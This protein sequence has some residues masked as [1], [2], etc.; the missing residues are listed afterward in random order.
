MAVYVIFT[1]IAFGSLAHHQ[2]ELD[3]LAYMHDLNQIHQDLSAIFTQDRKLPGRP[4]TDLV[5][6]LVYN[7]FGPNPAAFHITIVICHL[8]ATILLTFTF[9]KAG[10]NTELSVLSGFFFLINLAHF[11][12]VQWISCLAYP[13]SLGFGCLGILMYITYQKNKQTQWYAISLLCFLLGLLSHPAAITFPLFMAYLAYQQKQP[14]RPIGILN[15][16][17]ITCL[18]LLLKLF[19]NVPQAEHATAAL[20]WHITDF[21]QHGFWYLGRLWTTT[22]IIFPQMSEIYTPDLIMGVLALVGVMLLLY[23][24]VVSVAQWGIWMLLGLAAFITNPNQTHFESGPSRHLY[25]ASAGSAAILAWIS[26]QISIKIFPQKITASKICLA[27]LITII[28]AFSIIG[29]KKSETFA[30]IISARTF[31]VTNQKE[32]ATH[33]FEKAVDIAPELVSSSM[34]ENFLITNLAKGQFLNQ[35]LHQAIALYPHNTVIVAIR[36][37]YGFQSNT[38]DHQHLTERIVEFAKKETPDTQNMIAIACLNL[39]YYYTSQEKT[40]AAETLFQGALKIQTGYPEAAI[41]LSRIY[42]SQNKISEARHVLQS[43]V[44]HNP[45]HG[46]VLKSLADIYALENNWPQAISAYEKVL[47]QKPK[48]TDVRFKL[49]YLYLVQKQYQKA[50][51]HFETLTQLSPESWQ[52]FAYLGQCLHA[53]GNFDAAKRA[54]Q[55]ALQINPDQPELQ[56]LLR[57]ITQNN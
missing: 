20:Q 18:I 55:R 41:H 34:Y 33:Y 17:A 57:H 19:P 49:G 36:M 10:L 45:T 8:I 26:Q 14:L 39:G 3:D 29:L 53:E 52:S 30:Y 6:L 9:H 24:R 35:H 4:V 48:N 21:I 15:I 37:I 25:F 5:L 43:A 11:R 2:F 51:P 38:V 7:I 31:L 13:L 16:I 12:A 1:A 22:F 50:K 40:E 28:T 42:T 46:E 44:Q 47:D 23:Y 54:Y 32:E 56:T 27:A